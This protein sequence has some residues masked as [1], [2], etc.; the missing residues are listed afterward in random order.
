MKILI[1]G[2]NGLLGQKLIEL[3]VKTPDVE[4]LALARGENRNIE[5]QGYL[6]ADVNLLDHKAL[7]QAFVDFKPEAIIHTAAITNVDYCESHKEECDELNINI[8]QFLWDLCKKHHVFMTHLSTD[9]IFDGKKGS[10]YTEVDEPNPLSYYGKSKLAS[11]EIF[12]QDENTHWAIARTILV[13]GLVNKMSRSN[14][15]LWVVESLRNNKPLKI[16]TDQFRSPTLAEDL[17]KGCLQLT[18]NQCSG[19]YNVS[20]NEYISVYDFVMQIV[21]VFNLDASLVEA[22]DSQK[23]AQPANRPPSTGFVL[24][25]IKQKTGY[26]P[27]KIKQGLELL[28]TQL[29]TQTQVK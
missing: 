2:A 9:F 27:L 16:V 12:T 8:T 29:A 26:E 10:P 15:A 18:L 7:E 22:T 20:G 6:Y 25:K 3:C 1:T 5:K 14:I 13:Y 24:D 28:K 19:I 11:E 4:V 17:A 21:E 23:L